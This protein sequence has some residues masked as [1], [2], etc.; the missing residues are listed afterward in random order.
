M[1]KKLVTVLHGDG[2]GIE[3]VSAACRIMEEKNF[4][5]ELVRMPNGEAALEKYGTVLP[6]ETKKQCESSDAILFGTVHATYSR[7]QHNV[8]DCPV[9][10]L[11]GLELD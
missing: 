8:V 2:V 4:P 9:W 3:V 1:K 7:T 10:A 5:V 6:E 11:C